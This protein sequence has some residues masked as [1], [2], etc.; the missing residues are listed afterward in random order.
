M[1]TQ[2]YTESTYRRRF[3]SQGASPCVQGTSG[4]CLGLSLPSAGSTINTPL[5]GAELTTKVMDAIESSSFS[6]S[7]RSPVGTY[8]ADK[9]KVYTDPPT[10]LHA[11]RTMLEAIVPIP[12]ACHVRGVAYDNTTRWSRLGRRYVCHYCPGVNYLLFEFCYKC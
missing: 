6:C 4:K 8:M 11:R 2:A 1:A 12:V 9:E 3:L 10:R 5:V 7:L